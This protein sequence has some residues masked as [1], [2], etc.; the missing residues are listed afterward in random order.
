MPLEGFHSLADE[1]IVR[2]LSTHWIKYVAPTFA[3][4][5][6]LS[7]SVALLA[8][9]DALHTNADGMSFILLFSGL[10][11][12]Y[13]SVHWYFHTLLSEA[14]EDVIITTKRIIWIKE[15]LFAV[16]DMRQIPLDRIQGVEARKHGLAQTILGYGT[17]W[18]DTGGTGTAEKNAMMNLVPHPNRIAGEINQLLRLK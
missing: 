11:L 13:L 7:A 18:F 3:F 10:I 9:A 6:V 16:D 17:L 14:M 4:L 12:T 1:R 15:S 5:I 2:T 8:G